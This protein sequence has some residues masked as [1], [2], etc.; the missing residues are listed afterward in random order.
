MSLAV[1]SDVVAA[2]GVGAALQGEFLHLFIEQEGM[3]GSRPP[4]RRCSMS[5][6]SKSGIAVYCSERLQVVRREVYG[7]EQPND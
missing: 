1:H 6:V 5:H 4:S 7:G 2:E 3:A